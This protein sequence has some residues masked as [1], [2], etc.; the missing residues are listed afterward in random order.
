MKD[1]LRDALEGQILQDAISG[2]T[3][4]LAEILLKLTDR[5]IFGCLGDDLQGELQD[6]YPSLLYYY[7]IHVCGKNGFSTTVSSK[8]ELDDDDVIMLGYEQ[9]K[10]NGDDC[11]FIDY[12]Q[13]LDYTEWDE[14]FNFNKKDLDII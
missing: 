9:D 8:H 5:Y 13:E 11:H 6:K 7:E 4:V 2:D 3:T 1:L 14:H 12:V 10:L